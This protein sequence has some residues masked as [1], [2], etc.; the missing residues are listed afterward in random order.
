MN[1]MGLNSGTS[2]NLSRRAGQGM[3]ITSSG[4]PYEQL[5]E[6]QIVR[7]DVPGKWED[8]SR[9]S[10]EW[11][12]HA[13][14]Y[15]QRPE[16]DAIVH[17]HPPYCTTLACLHRDI[18]PF[19]YEVALAG[20]HNV[21]C[22]PYATFGSQALSDF[23]ITALKDRRACLM[24]NHGLICLGATLGEALALARDLEFLARTY[25]QCLAIAEPELLSREE[26][27]RVVELFKN[28]GANANQGLEREP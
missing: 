13:D 24:A 27:Q 9:P 5:S 15:L 22:A 6:R 17:A 7:V 10:S 21:R 25:C 18:P 12:I 16:V 8:T 3:L 2:G 28:Y 20:G 14:I 11:R 4:I 19:H 23:V 1:R 26:M